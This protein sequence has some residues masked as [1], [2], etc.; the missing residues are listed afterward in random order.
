VVSGRPMGRGGGYRLVLLQPG[1][2]CWRTA[3][4]TRAKP[5]LDT[6]DYFLAAKAARK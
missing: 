5:I 3:M 6:Q 4:A 2:T 1:S